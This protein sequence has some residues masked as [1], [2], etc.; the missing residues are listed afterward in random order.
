MT[1]RRF[2]L[3]MLPSYCSPDWNDREPGPRRASH[4]EYSITAIFQT[5]ARRTWRLSRFVHYPLPQQS[6]SPIKIPEQD[7][8][9]R[10]STSYSRV[11]PIGRDVARS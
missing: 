9:S 3:L 10:W 11:V 7:V 8:R 4:S 6:F 1:A 5:T 2:F